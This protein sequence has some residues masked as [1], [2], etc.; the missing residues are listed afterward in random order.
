MDEACFNCMKLVLSTHNLSLTEAIENHIIKRVQKLEK[1]HQRAVD[2]R[3]TLEHNE[4]RAPERQF[5]CNMRLGVRGPD[6]FAEHT[7]S[8]MYA[9][10]DK[11]VKKLEQQLRERHSK[12]KARKHK[13]AVR[14]KTK[15]QTEG[16]L[17]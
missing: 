10:I 12:A 8:D 7:D 13:E 9:A 5:T 1:L 2:V 4:T 14:H 17:L 6:L 3:V 15:R 11:V 16:R